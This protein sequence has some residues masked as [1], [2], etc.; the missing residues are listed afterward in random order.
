MIRLYLHSDL[1]KADPEIQRVAPGRASGAEDQV[2][3][4]RQTSHKKTG[5]MQRVV[6]REERKYA[7]SVANKPAYKCKGCGSHVIPH[8]EDKYG[9]PVNQARVVSP[10]G[11]VTELAHGT[12]RSEMLP[13]KGESGRKIRGSCPS[14]HVSGQRKVI[15]RTTGKTPEEASAKMGAKTVKCLN[16]LDDIEWF[17]KPMKRREGESSNEFMSRTIRHLVNDK[18]YDQKRA[19]A[20]AYQ[21]TGHPKAGKPVKKSVRLVLSL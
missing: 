3:R 18:G 17:G 12:L 13:T 10:K 6:R 9:D 1:C 20:A 5:G 15:A 11:R 16:M 2:M 14:C 4:V 19:V 21:M 8:R 7:A